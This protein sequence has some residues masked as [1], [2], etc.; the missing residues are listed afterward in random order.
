M[1]GGIGAT[2]GLVGYCL[3]LVSRQA[4]TQQQQQWYSRAEAGHH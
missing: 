3:Y 2:T 4:G 1:M